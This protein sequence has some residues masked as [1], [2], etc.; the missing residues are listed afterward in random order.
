[1]AATKGEQEFLSQKSWEIY[2][3]M[4]N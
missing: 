4:C 3:K 1:M 2:N